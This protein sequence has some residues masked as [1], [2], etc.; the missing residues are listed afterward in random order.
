MAEFGSVTSFESNFVT[1]WEAWDEM[2]VG[3]LYFYNVTFPNILK[4]KLKKF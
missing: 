1:A 2:G 4:Q 3:E